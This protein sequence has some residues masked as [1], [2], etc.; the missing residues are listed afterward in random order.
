MSN[1]RSDSFIEPVIFEQVEYSRLRFGDGSELGFVLSAE[2][3]AM[4]TASP[5]GL[6][7]LTA[8]PAL[9]NWYVTIRF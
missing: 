7:M 9:L 1:N 5:S 3:Y 8:C 4:N 6:R 2:L